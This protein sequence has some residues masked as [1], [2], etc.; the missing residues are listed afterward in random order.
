MLKNTIQAVSHVLQMNIF[1]IHKIQV[2][3]ILIILLLVRAQMA[4]I[5]IA[6]QA[7]RKYFLSKI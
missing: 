6:W 4:R 2:E 7:H 1:H 3:V 5:L